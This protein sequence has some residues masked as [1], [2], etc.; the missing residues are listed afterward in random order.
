M[1]S[2]KSN[3]S[4]RFYRSLS[5]DKFH[6]LSR[7]LSGNFGR[8]HQVLAVEQLMAHGSTRR[9][10]IRTPILQRIESGKP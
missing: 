4:E 10:A 7:D 9:R 8:L 1:L 3:R 5:K 2:E 6:A